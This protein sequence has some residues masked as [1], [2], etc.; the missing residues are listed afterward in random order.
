MS[1]QHRFTKNK[2]VGSG[3]YGIVYSATSPGGRKSAIKYNLKSEGFDFACCLREMNINHRLGCHPHIVPLTRINEGEPFSGPRSPIVEPYTRRDK[4]HFVYPLAVGD[5]K[6]FI[7]DNGSKLTVDEMRQFMTE[8][9][10]SVEYIHGKGFIHRD[11]KPENILVIN[12]ENGIPRLKLGDFGLS[13]PFNR[14]ENQTPNVMTSWFRPPEVVLGS[15]SYDQSSDMWSVG[16][17]FYEIVS[18]YSLIETEEDD[19]KLLIKEIVN[20]LPYV[21]SKTL[22]S[23]LDTKK[24]FRNLKIP[25][26]RKSLRDFFKLTTEGVNVFERYGGWQNFCDLMI[27]LLQADPSL[28]LTATDALKSPFLNKSSKYIEGIRSLFPCVPRNYPKVSISSGI[29]RRWVMCVSLGIFRSRNHYRWYSHRILF[30]SISIMDRALRV[31]E[32][33]NKERTSSVSESDL[34]ETTLSKD[35]TEL[36]Y[37][38]ALYMAIKYFSTLQ[39]PISLSDITTTERCTKDNLRIMEKFE[40]NLIKN[41]LRYDIYHSTVYDF[42]AQQERVSDEDAY[43]ILVFIINGHHAGTS[44]SEAHSTWKRN[45]KRYVSAKSGATRGGDSS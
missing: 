15:T 37:F 44:V 1:R 41:I 39:E 20:R 29:E 2:K 3:T 40:E 24:R 21:V 12:D 23:S 35:L 30:Q 14:Y 25:E 43:G 4:I 33:Q 13:K 5:L 11:I 27:G 34:S 7:N 36:Y 32:L 19:N 31:I 18:G 16:C 45:K 10:L 6:N 26:K 28:R 22:I 38:V 17:T 42:Q 8:I 9:L